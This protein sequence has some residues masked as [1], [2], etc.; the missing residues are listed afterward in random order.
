MN[1]D[2]NKLST[3]T[4]LR[5]PLTYHDKNFMNVMLRGIRILSNIYILDI[6]S[7]RKNIKAIIIYGLQYFINERMD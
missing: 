1:K 5:M 6:N 3:K 4:P 2:K 7:K